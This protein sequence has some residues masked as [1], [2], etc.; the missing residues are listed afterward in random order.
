MVLEGWGVVGR[1]VKDEK[2]EHLKNPFFKTLGY[3]DRWPGGLEKRIRR[4]TGR[5]HRAAHS[6]PESFSRPPGRPCMPT[7]L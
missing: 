3:P 7:A 6:G 1:P 2:K 4:K 5:P